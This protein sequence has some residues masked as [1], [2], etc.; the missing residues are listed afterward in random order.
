MRVGVALPAGIP[1]AEPD[2]I[3]DWAANADQGP[4][5]HLAIVDR[6]KYGNYEPFVV[7]SAAAAVTRRVRL[8]TTVLI[9]TLRNTIVV[10]KQAASLDRISDGR[11]VLGLGL[12]ARADDYEVTGVEQRTRGGD[13]SH[14]ITAMRSVWESTAIGPEPKRSGGPSILL[15]GS[16]G[17]AFGRMARYADGYIHGGGPPRA[18]ARAIAQARAAWVDLGRPGQPELWGQAYFALGDAVEKGRDYMRDYYAFTGPFAEKLAAGMLSTPQEIEEFAK[19]YEE[20]G[21]GELSLLPAVAELDQLERLADVV[22][23]LG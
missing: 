22:G 20:E 1:G 14:Q 2:V 5:S 12:G 8:A 6:I 16:T 23:S 19:A 11:F 21:C 15:G 9:S 3:V 4:F 10:A 13:L 18:F 17:P 7:L